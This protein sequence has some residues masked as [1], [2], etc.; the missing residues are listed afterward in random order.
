MHLRYPP[1]L[2]AAALVVVAVTSLLG[3]SVPL[4]LA[5]P[6]RYRDDTVMA[7]AHQ[8]VLDARRWNPADRRIIS[9][10]GEW[11]FY[12]GELLDP[13]DIPP[14]PPPAYLTLPTVLSPQEYHGG[15][16][17]LRIDLEDTAA[18]LRL[19]AL[20]LGSGY[21]IWIGGELTAE[22][23]TVSLDRETN[24][25]AYQPARITVPRG[26][27]GQETR[28]V[29]IQFANFHHRRVRLNEIF[30][31]SPERMAMITYRG[32][33]HSAVLLGSFVF[34]ALY[35][36]I[37]YLLQRENRANLY[38]TLIASASAV[39][40]MVVSE[41]IIMVLIPPLPPEI[42]MK[43]GYLGGLLMVPLVVLFLGAAVESPLL[44]WPLHGA[45]A[46]AI[47]SL[48]I[49]GAAPLRVYD[50]LYPAVQG[51]LL[52][53][54]GWV[55][56][57][58]VRHRLL[59]DTR[60]RIPFV[61]AGIVLLAAGGHDVLRELD[62]LYTPEMFSFGMVLFLL[63]QGLFLAWQFHD[64]YVYAGELAGE[65]QSL[66]TVLEERIAERTAELEKTNRKLEELTRVD[67]LTE[68]ANR[69]AADEWLEHVSRMAMRDRSPMAVLMIDLDSFKPYNDNYG[70]PA[71]D[72]CLRSVAQVLR[73]CC[74][75]PG[76]LPARYGGEEFVVILADTT[77]EGAV[78]LGEK[79]RRRIEE[80][81][82]PHGYSAAAPVV[83][84]SVGAAS[85]EGDHHAIRQVVHR[86]D[87]ALYLAKSRGKN[88]V[89]AVPVPD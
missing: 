67:P 78:A 35:F 4:I 13:G 48:V 29:V 8:G 59:A 28:E 26:G 39:R 44:K 73:E 14:G 70:H 40:L 84:A 22:S 34:A 37:M 16:L 41:R 74:S 77:L 1:G 42:M 5:N 65:V 25:P 55:V 88:R 6:D 12:P 66:N 9:L 11:Q 87:Q 3:Y 24:R 21:R 71:G 72:T 76:D 32:L 15:T 58:L 53:G 80:Q 54:G 47:V 52:A 2:S 57:L 89:E 56:Y 31:G 36:L 81:E 60:R 33:V 50:A 20:Y 19:H 64:T 46:G 43:A 27:G 86:A 49:V 63:L 61:V 7:S 30:L 45:R 38:L 18:P 75:R 62:V 83:T 51:V 79:I 10:A 23:G 17:R 85:S 69:R 82:I 68:L